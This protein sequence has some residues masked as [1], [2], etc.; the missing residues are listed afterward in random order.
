MPA[1]L[2]VS[3]DE[4]VLEKD[5]LPAVELIFDSS[6]SMKD[7]IDGRPK[8]EIARAVLTEVTEGLSSDVLVGLRLYG[9]RGVWIARASDPRAGPLPANDPRVKTDTEL[10][11]PIGRLDDRRRAEIRRRI[12]AAQPLGWTPM[13]HSLLEATKDFPPK[14]RAPRTVV[15]VSDGEETGG[16]KLEDVAKAYRDSDIGAKIHVVGFDIAGTPAE[17]QLQEIARLGGGR[18]Y[19]ARNAKEL[20]EGL[21][22]AVPSLAFEAVDEKGAVVARGA[23]ND[24]PVEV[25]PGRYRVRLAGFEGE[26]VEVTLAEGDEAALDVDGTGRLAPGS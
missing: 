20:A 8:I 4:R 25:P 15:L 13:V 22:A 9:H 12:H 17:K 5:L 24:E 23:V 21:R 11:V 2:S 7:P 16:G 18:Y 6:G 14:G 1:L 26:P 10:V 19:G 3:C